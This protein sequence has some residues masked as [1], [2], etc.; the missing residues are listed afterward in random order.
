[1]PADS[2]CEDLSPPTDTPWTRLD[3]SYGLSLDGAPGE[4]AA[5][6]G[7]RWR[8]PRSHGQQRSFGADWQHGRRGERD[9]M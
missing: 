4:L 5:C 7:C 6:P 9:A 3:N 8:A 2:E 1:M